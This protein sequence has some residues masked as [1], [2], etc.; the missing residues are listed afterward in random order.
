MVGL[1]LNRED[2]D[3]LPKGWTLPNVAIVVACISSTIGSS[4]TVGVQWQRLNNVDTRVERVEADYVPR[5]VFTQK[6]DSL[7][8]SIDQLNRTLERLQDIPVD[9][10]PRPAYRPTYRPPPS[11]PGRMFDR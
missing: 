2:D 7:K 4:L 6:V 10:A 1:N 11:P 8:E 9:P 3:M 5:E